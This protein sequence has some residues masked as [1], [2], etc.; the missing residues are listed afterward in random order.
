MSTKIKL[1]NRPKNIKAVVSFK[2]IEGEDCKIEVSYIYRTR[3]E[4]GRFIDEVVEQNQRRAEE[5]DKQ[6]TKEA[7]EAGRTL[8]AF[9][10]A[11]YQESIAESNAHLIMGAVD[12]WNLDVEFNLDNVRQL[13]DE[14][15]AGAQAIIDGY[16]AA[17]TEGRLGN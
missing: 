2:S 16:R 4:F 1:G 7:E 12:G 17:M 10:S 9:S 15:P 13:V 5:T 11:T 14:F 3:K 6:R 8:P